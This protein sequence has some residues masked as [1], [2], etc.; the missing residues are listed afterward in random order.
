MLNVERL[1]IYILLVRHKKNYENS[2]VS[3]RQGINIS[4]VSLKRLD[5]LV[6]PLIRQ[7]QSIK[8]IYSNHKDEI[9]CSIRCL[10]NYIDAA[11]LSV[12]NI[13]LPRRVKYKVRNKTNK[14]WKSSINYDI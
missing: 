14:W 8:L 12:K 7:G 6:S 9:A 10:Y 1:N 11:L 13:D 5:D 2:L 4:E 3:S